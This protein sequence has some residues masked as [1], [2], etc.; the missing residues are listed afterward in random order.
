MD[1]ELRQLRALLAIIEHGSFNKAAEA[2][3]LTQ[4]AIS[5]SINQ[6]ER[7]LGVR[8]FERGRNGAEVTPAGLVLARTAS[9]TTQLIAQARMELRNADQGITG[10]LVIG[11]TPSA[12]LGLV[13]KVCARLARKLGALDL[14][15]REGLDAELMPLLESGEINLLVGP[16]SDLYAPPPH[17]VEEVLLEERFQVGMAPEN[18]LARHRHLRLKE[19]IDVPWVLPSKGSRTY[20]LVE[21]LFLNEAV[22]WPRDVILT[23]ALAA[24]EQIVMATDRLLLLTDVQLIARQTDMVV[25]PLLGSPMRRFG[26]RSLRHA[27]KSP[28]IVEFISTLQEVIAAAG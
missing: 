12:M 1:P 26:W 25:V 18:S 8:L 5:K 28:L 23:N 17:I 4:P 14:T 9:G 16:I 19:L 3:G 13:P 2:L 22:A 27:V 24:Q 6:L 15:I 20:Q 21:A 7:V 11:A 10:P